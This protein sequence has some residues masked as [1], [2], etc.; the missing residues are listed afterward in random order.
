[1]S[2]DFSRGPRRFATHQ[3]SN[4]A[5]HAR[6]GDGFCIAERRR[7]T[8]AF[9]PAAAVLV[10]STAWGVATGRLPRGFPP[11]PASLERSAERAA[12]R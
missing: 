4:C 5:L 8:L 7:S 10:G 6:T 9:L 2:D 1:M 3:L 11:P 12:A